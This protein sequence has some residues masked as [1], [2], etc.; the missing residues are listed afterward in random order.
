M[1]AHAG[2]QG[3]RANKGELWGISNLFK[4]TADRVNAH[5]IFDQE[6]PPTRYRIQQCN[7]EDMGISSLLALTVL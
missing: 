4:E 6:R 5:E 7:P 3:D 2:V 1:R